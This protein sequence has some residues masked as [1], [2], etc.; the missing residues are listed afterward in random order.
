MTAPLI[1]PNGSYEG[2]FDLAVVPEVV[3]I[4][5]STRQTVHICTFKAH[6]LSLNKASFG[7]YKL[8]LGVPFKEKDLA[9]EL[10]NYDGRMLELVISTIMRAPT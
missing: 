4:E 1:P 3:D 10:T 7:D 6:Y 8:T 9:W 2:K 5:T